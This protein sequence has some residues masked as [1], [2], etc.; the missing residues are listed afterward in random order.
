VRTF[1]ELSLAADSALSYTNKCAAPHTNKD[2][3]R[4]GQ[5]SSSEPPKVKEGKKK[6]AFADVSYV[7]LGSM[8]NMNKLVLI[9]YLYDHDS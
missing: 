7:G 1:R 9:A 3:I 8:K 5:R 2:N 4:I 6:Q